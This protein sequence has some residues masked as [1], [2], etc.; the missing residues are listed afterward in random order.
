MAEIHTMTVRW[1]GDGALA[2]AMA[3]CAAELGHAPS[4]TQD[5]ASHTLT[6]EVV[7]AD[8]QALRDRV[9]DLLVAMSALEEQHKG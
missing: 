2:E 5:E 4:L 6:V 3:A 1:S 9:D 7:D 8:L